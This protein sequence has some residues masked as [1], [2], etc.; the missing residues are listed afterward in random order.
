MRKTSQY[1][2][3]SEMSFAVEF[4]KFFMILVQRLFEDSIYLR[5]AFLFF[6]NAVYFIK[7]PTVTLL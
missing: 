2:I 5:L 6:F 3:S 7:Q 4:I 1:R